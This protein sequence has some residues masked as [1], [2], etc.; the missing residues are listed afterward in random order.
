MIQ[1]VCVNSTEWASPKSE[2]THVCECLCGNT[3]GS[4]CVDFVKHW[5][6]D[7]SDPTDATVAS[8]YVCMCLRQCMCVCVWVRSTY[9]VDVNSGS[10]SRWTLNYTV[11]QSVKVTNIYLLIYLLITLL[12]DYLLMRRWPASKTGSGLSPSYHQKGLPDGLD[13]DA[14]LGNQWWLCP[15]CLD[16]FV[17]CCISWC[18]TGTT[19]V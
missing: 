5:L 13:H 8:Q 19:D 17:S 3:E 9:C 11:Y 15:P 6:I 1:N 7:W 2:K 14:M 12:L 18:T 16:S 10:N 4:S